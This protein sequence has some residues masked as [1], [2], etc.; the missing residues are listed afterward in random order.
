MSDEIWPYINPEAQVQGLLQQ[1]RRPELADF[2]QNAATYGALSAVHQKVYDN[3]RRYYDQDMKYYSRQRDQLQ[4]ARAYITATVSQA[5]KTSLDPQ[6]SVRE[7]LMNLKRDTEPPK[8]YMLTQIETRYND[9]LKSFKQSRMLQWLEE[10]EATM[11]ECIKYD[12]PEVKNGRWLRDLAQRI[13]LASEVYYV[14]FMKD[15]NDDTR[16]DPQEFRRVARELRETLGPKS[17]RTMRGSAFHASFEPTE[18]LEEGSE[19]IDTEETEKATPKGRNGRKRPGTQ[20]LESKDSKKAAT[21]CP[22]CGMRGHSLAECWCI[23]EELKPQ[24][25][26]LSAY[27][28]RKAKKA[29]ADNEELK[30]QVQ[31]IQQK[32]KKD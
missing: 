4:A 20:S 10:W 26:T 2:D 25:M 8:G 15:A 30:A 21:E 14:Q 16:S 17:V 18:S 6:L 29:V 1:P 27:R 11:V 24:E 32:I 12:L 28:V 22:A 3:A 5:K 9:T 31:E 7:W 13:R 23:F 19:A